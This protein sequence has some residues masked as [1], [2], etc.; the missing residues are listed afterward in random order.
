MASKSKLFILTIAAALSAGA[1]Q[2]ALVDTGSAP[3]GID[4]SWTVQQIV[5]SNPG[6]NPPN[7]YI[8]PYVP[9]S[10]PFQYWGQPLLGSQWIVPTVGGPAVSL[11]PSTAG[12]YQYNSGLFAVGAG[13]GSFSGN[14]MTDNTVT[15]IFVTNT[16]SHAASTF[17]SGTGIGGFGVGGESP[18]SF[19]LGAGTYQ[20]SFVVE[21]FAQN[22]GN[23]SSLDVAF[24][25]RSGVSAV[26][27]PSTWAMMFL[28]FLSV[29][30]MAY[31]RKPSTRL[32]LA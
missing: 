28:G 13:G 27:E 1:A 16:S 5:G 24:N 11:D 22:G 21:N 6:L 15:D 9:N 26:P 31:R 12:F 29:G 18:F 2:A 8:A 7:A 4:P 23:P 20:L 30:F 10:F 14:F 19:T 25:E 32:R 17:Y 3:S